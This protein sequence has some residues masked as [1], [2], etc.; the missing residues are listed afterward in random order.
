MIEAFGGKLPQFMLT[1]MLLLGFAGMAAAYFA[2]NMSDK[3]ADII[4][5]VLAGI[6]QA[7]LLALG[8]WFGQGGK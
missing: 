8:Y 1:I 5:Q 4:K 2:V 6:G 7:C 3:N